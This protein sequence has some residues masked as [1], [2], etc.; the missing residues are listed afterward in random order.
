MMLWR[1]RHML[2]ML[3]C[4]WLSLKA[5]WQIFMREMWRR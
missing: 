5:C 1:F 4:E 2:L 3:Q